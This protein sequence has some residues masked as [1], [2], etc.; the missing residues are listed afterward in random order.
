MKN[1]E[2]II[3]SFYKDKE[4]RGTMYDF[5]REIKAIYTLPKLGENI[6]LS[7]IPEKCSKEYKNIN[8][9]NT[10]IYSE[11]VF[12]RNPYYTDQKDASFFNIQKAKNPVNLDQIIS[13]FNCGNGNSLQ[14]FCR[15]LG[16]NVDIKPKG[17]LYI[18]QKNKKHNTIGLHLDCISGKSILDKYTR[19]LYKENLQILQQFINNNSHKY[20]F[21]QFGQSLGKDEINNKIGL[22]NNVEDYLDKTLAETAEKIAECEYFICVNSAFYHLSISLDIKTICII[23]LPSIYDCYLPI[24]VNEMLLC[25]PPFLRWEKN[26]LY[27]QAV[28]LHQDGENHLVKKFSI[29]NL[30]KAINGEVY[31]FWN[32]K[33]LNLINDFKLTN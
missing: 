24:L 4:I 10:N 14:Q 30:E 1:P 3:I 13:N 9:L 28:H 31:P 19:N 16:L 2:D 29:I 27:P 22:L 23:S 6:L 11:F 21:I 8:F 5:S 32:D 26:C 20:Q 15:A 17:N 12:S 18:P 7:S 25:K 33:Y